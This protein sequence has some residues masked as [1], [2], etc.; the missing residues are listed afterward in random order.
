V[1]ASLSEFAVVEIQIVFDFRCGKKLLKMVDHSG[2]ILVDI[3]IHWIFGR[4]T[5]KKKGKRPPGPVRL[6]FPVRKIIGRIGKLVLTLEDFKKADRPDVTAVKC[7]MFGKVTPL[8]RGDG[9]RRMLIRGGEVFVRDGPVSGNP[10]QPLPLYR[11]R[12]LRI[13]GEQWCVAVEGKFAVFRE[14]FLPNGRLVKCIVDYLQ[15]LDSL[16]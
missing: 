2:R 11:H 12:T 7:G 1:I 4:Q 8:T 14:I 13:K 9:F 5:A 16:L 3:A 10:K 15:S 6:D